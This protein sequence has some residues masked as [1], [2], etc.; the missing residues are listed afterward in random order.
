MS[1]YNYSLCKFQC[2]TR[3]PSIPVGQ[4]TCWLACPLVPVCEWRTAAPRLSRCRSS[5]VNT[6]PLIT[7][8]GDG[9]PQQRRDALTG[10]ERGDK[11]E[12]AEA[13]AASSERPVLF[14]DRLLRWWATQNRR[15]NNPTGL[16]SAYIS[17]FSLLHY[18]WLNWLALY[19]QHQCLQLVH[20][21]S[22]TMVV[23]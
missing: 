6:V 1:S 3:P 4:N 10:S 23:Y 21:I 5:Q 22:E 14:E 18:Y 16:L 13:A 15:S 12:A 17:P 7:R 11:P 8:G 20:K 19:C 2:L 9:S